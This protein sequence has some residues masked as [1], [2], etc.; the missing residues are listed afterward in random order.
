MF[1]GQKKGGSDDPVPLS[2]ITQYHGIGDWLSVMSVATAT[3]EFPP[4]QS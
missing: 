1:L 3:S 4:H 2:L